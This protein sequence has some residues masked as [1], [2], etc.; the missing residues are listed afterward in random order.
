MYGFL[1]K[2]G[3]I[4]HNKRKN[5]SD[6]SSTSVLVKSARNTSVDYGTA[7]ECS[8]GSIVNAIHEANSVLGGDIVSASDTSVFESTEN[9]ESSASVNNYTPGTPVGVSNATPIHTLSIVDVM[10]VLKGLQVQIGTVSDKLWKL[11]SLE[12]KVGSFEIEIRKIWSFHHDNLK[13]SDEKF[14]KMMDR[15]DNLEFSLGAAGDQITQMRQD[16]EHVDDTFYTCNRNQ[17]V[18]I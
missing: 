6:G 14:T 2:I 11:D 12:Q 16:K 7:R 18:T 3:R 15:L 17:C 4:K 13:S 5:S 8:M 10:A 9:E 1:I